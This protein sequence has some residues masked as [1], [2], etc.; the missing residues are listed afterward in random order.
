MKELKREK[1]KK[2]SEKDI[3]DDI[4]SDKEI[5]N[6]KDFLDSL[7][8]EETLEKIQEEAVSD[9]VIVDFSERPDTKVV[10]KAEPEKEKTKENEQPE[11]A[12]APVVP[13]KEKKVEKEVQAEENVLVKEEKQTEKE[14]QT[15]Q[16]DKDTTVVYIDFTEKPDVK[17]PNQEKDSSK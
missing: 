8:M 11:N 5:E 4:F 12:E 6:E 14:I 16:K 10:E 17:L 2:R 13:E 15:E 9:D 7:D 3:L 1:L